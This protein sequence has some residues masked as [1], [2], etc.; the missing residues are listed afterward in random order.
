MRL[1]GWETTLSYYGWGVGDSDP[2]ALE[3]EADARADMELTPER[4]ET[5]SQVSHIRCFAG[6]VMEIRRP[7]LHDN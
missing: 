4:K 3:P 6:L 7:T 5:L 1:F 2:R